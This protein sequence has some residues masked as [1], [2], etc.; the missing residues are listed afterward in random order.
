ML[1]SFIFAI[2]LFLFFFSESAFSA[3]VR[4]TQHNKNI[5]ADYTRYTKK[6]RKEVEDLESTNSHTLIVSDS[7]E[8]KDKLH[9]DIV[10]DNDKSLKQFAG[11]YRQA[12]T[13]LSNAFSLLNKSNTSSSGSY[14]SSTSS[15]SSDIGSNTA[16]TLRSAAASTTANISH[17]AA[18][19]IAT[20]TT[21]ILAANNTPIVSLDSATASISKVSGEI[22]LESSDVSF[23]AKPMY[24]HT[25]A[26]DLTAGDY[27]YGYTSNLY[28]ASIGADYAYTPNFL[29]GLAA[30]GGGGESKS[31]QEVVSS[32]NNFFYYGASLYAGYQL[33]NLDLLAD[34]GYTITSNNIR[35]EEIKTNFNSSAFSLGFRTEYLIKTT[36]LDVI[37]Y[38][39]VRVNYLTSDGHDITYNDSTAYYSEKSNI[40]NYDFP[41]GAVFQKNIVTSSGLII[42]PGVDLGVQFTAGER[43]FKNNVQ[44]PTVNS[45]ATIESE[46]F[47][48][49]TFQ[50]GASLGL[51]K[52]AASLNLSYKLNTSDK[53][54]SHNVQFTIKHTF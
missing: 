6:S 36:T 33:G 25:Y 47:S 26:S 1:V 8:S 7:K 54:T 2:M 32:K 34:I 53:A 24:Q 11:S 46:V 29:V 45:T 17:I 41:I 42:Q 9:T 40:T 37:P 48:P 38:S 22:D 20:R 14:T 30:H 27:T 12:D 21:A 39:G 16:I 52:D 51:K 10:L 19:N 43:N 31:K 15:T 35:Q 44:I 23:W 18:D 5:T 49:V 3:E 28:G 4:T 13:F 50:A